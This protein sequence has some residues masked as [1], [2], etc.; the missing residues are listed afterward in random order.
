MT[1]VTL[2]VV[3][4]ALVSWWKP[5][6]GLTLAKGLASLDQLQS[7]EATQRGSWGKETLRYIKPAML[8][9]DQGN[10][11]LLHRDGQTWEVNEAENRATR[12]A[13]V[14]MTGQ[15]LNLAILLHLP[16]QVD[17]C[18]EPV[19]ITTPEP[20]MEERLYH[21]GRSSLQLR[22]LVDL[23]TKQ[24]VKFTLI[25][26]A[27]QPVQE[28][29]FVLTTI[30]VPLANET[31]QLKDTLS[32][33]GRVGI[34]Q[35]IQ[36]IVAVRPVGKE[37]WTPLAVGD[38]LK[39]GDLVSANPRGPNAA[40][41]RMVPNTDVTFGPGATLEVKTPTEYRL[42]SGEIEVHPRGRKV[43]VISPAASGNDKTV[44]DAKTLLQADAEKLV[45]LK[46]QPAWL[47]GFQGTVV[48]ESLGQ[49]LCKVGDQ[50]VPLSVGYHKVDVDIRDGLAR[51]TVEESF[52]NTTDRELEGTFYFPLPSDASIA[53]FG[54]WIGN[55]LI[56]ADIV[57]KQRAR[58]IF[59]IILSEK[60]DP[61]L[62]EW[63]GG[64]LFKTRVY[65]IPAHGM[66]RIKI[67]YTQRCPWKATASATATLSS[68]ICSNSIHSRN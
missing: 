57:E 29:E 64:N 59:D 30:N 37:R 44:V 7:F 18:E 8:R 11:Y 56:E 43:T 17:L 49:L 22:W 12:R 20:G 61:A 14:L 58:E 41:L 38:L 54:M 45:T 34:V 40:R 21:L 66:K 33:D 53:G 24:T 28:E 6:S 9:V 35:D 31:F 3:G 27:K 39:P 5:A 68:A 13:E 47:K 48:I 2:L 15:H 51:T 55:E 4:V 10:T 32:E 46:E 52:I 67:T 63:A 1:A 23:T 62:L 60:K 26:Q 42:L 25:D 65:P 50:N 36:G 16:R 19:Q